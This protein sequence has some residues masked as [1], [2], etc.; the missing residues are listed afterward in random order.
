MILVFGAWELLVFFEMLDWLQTNKFAAV[1]EV[2]GH[3]VVTIIGSDRMGGVAAVVV[4]AVIGI[5]VVNDLDS[6]RFFY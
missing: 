1:E 3:V 2:K 5:E 6:T 4:T